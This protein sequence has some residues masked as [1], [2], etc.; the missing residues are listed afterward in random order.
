MDIFRAG[1][2][3]DLLTKIVNMLAGLGDSYSFSQLQS[4]EDQ[5]VMMFINDSINKDNIRKVVFL[6]RDKIK[7]SDRLRK[8]FGRVSIGSNSSVLFI[9][10]KLKDIDEEDVLYLKTLCK[11]IR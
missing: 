8:F 7:S 11:L 3:R 10:V 5:C 1:E 2:V 4:T 6:L 9:E